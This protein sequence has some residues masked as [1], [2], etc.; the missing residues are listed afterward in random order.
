MKKTLLSLILAAGLSLAYGQTSHSIGNAGNVYIPDSIMANVGDTVIFNVGPTHPTAQTTQST[1]LANGTMAMAG[2]FDF[3]NGAGS[4]VIASTQTLYYVCQNHVASDNMKGRIFVQNPASS[5]E[6]IL[7]EVSIFPNP[8]E[9][10]LGMKM[11]YDR[12][13]KDISIIDMGGKTVKRLSLTAGAL[14]HSFDVSDLKAG[15]YILKIENGSTAK[16]MRFVKK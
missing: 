7:T 15:S 5:P 10:A 14:E 13:L 3:Q 6:D 9:D 2:G 12:D 4:F 1:W 16:E 11:K 8:V